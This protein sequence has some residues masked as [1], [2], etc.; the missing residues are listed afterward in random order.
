MKRTIKA[1]LAYFLGRDRSM[2]SIE[3]KA[4]ADKITNEQAE[5]IIRNI[6]GRFRL[7]IETDISRYS[8]MEIL[9]MIIRESLLTLDTRLGVLQYHARKR[10]LE[11]HFDTKGGQYDTDS[12]TRLSSG[13]TGL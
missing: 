6:P 3:W 9:E 7:L 4:L 10:L 11:L 1:N 8:E 2:D 12:H 5:E 13:T